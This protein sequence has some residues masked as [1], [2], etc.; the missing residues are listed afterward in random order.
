MW[1]NRCTMHAVLPYDHVN[2]RRITH[3]STI[4]GDERPAGEQ[5]PAVGRADS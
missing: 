5:E 4:V 3:R 1:D 2:R